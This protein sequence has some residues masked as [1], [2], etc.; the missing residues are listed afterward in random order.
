[1]EETKD[2]STHQHSIRH[3]PNDKKTC[4]DCDECRKGLKCRKPTVASLDPFE[5]GHK[6][7]EKLVAKKPICEEKLKRIADAYKTIIE[8]LGEDVEREGLLKTP[9]RAAKAMAYFT[10]G[11]E[12]SLQDTIGGAVFEEDHTEMVIVK[13]VQINS[14]CEHHLVPFVGKVHI[15]YVPNGKVLGLSKLARIAEMFSRRLQ[16]QERLT[17]QIANAIEEAIHPQGVAVVIEASHMCMVTRGVE[18]TGSS[19]STSSVLGIFQTDP[20]TRM[21]FFAHLA[22]GKH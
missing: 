10:K 20:R 5:A 3:S 6:T 2:L 7:R 14:L 4:D 22:R 12:T 9:M 11:Y 15:G 1:M 16:V 19:T 18:K 13:D 17:R 21:E 8:C